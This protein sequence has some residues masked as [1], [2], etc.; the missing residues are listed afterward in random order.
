M[1]KLKSDPLLAIGKFIV[2][3]AQALMALAGTALAIAIPV[4]LFLQGKAQ[5]ELR[6]ELGNPDF[7]FPTMSIVGLFALMLAVIVMAFFFF[8]RLRRIVNTVGEGDPFQPDNAER[9]TMMA[10]LMLGIQLLAIPTA[11]L[12]LYVSKLMEENDATVDA[13]FDLSGVVMVIVLFILARVFR[14]GAAM[15]ADLEGTV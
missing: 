14:H 11:G 2:I 6:A 7:I 15:R 9:L 5:A 10:W 8:D 4:V 1:Q 13:G 12:G 3:I